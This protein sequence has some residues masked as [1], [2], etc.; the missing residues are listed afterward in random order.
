MPVAVVSRFLALLALVSLL[1]AVAVV[2]G[3]TTRAGAPILAH[4]RPVALP[5]AAAIAGVATAGSLY[6][7]EILGFVPCRLCWWQ[8]IAMYPLALVL[9]VA[10]IRRDVSIRLSASLLAGA[11]LAVSTY[12]YVIERVPTLAGEAC[13]SDVPCTV[14]WVDEFGFASL[15]FMAG[16]GFIGILAL[17]AIARPLSEEEAS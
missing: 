5:L 7:S 11:G 12:H 9:T 4:L 6:Y 15:P 2:V 10:A 17:V 3:R 13:A 16:A 14:R 8:R 1:L